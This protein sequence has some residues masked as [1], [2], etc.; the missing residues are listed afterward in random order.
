[1]V[2]PVGLRFYSWSA[3]TPGGLSVNGTLTELKG[4]CVGQWMGW[5]ENAV[6]DTRWAKIIGM[7]KDMGINS[8]RTAHYPRADAFYHAC[9]SVGMMLLVEV[10]NWGTWGGFAGLTT[11]WTRMY[12]CDSE[13][14]LDAYNHPCIW[15]WSLF[16]EPT[17]TNLA[18][19]FANENTI[20]H[21]IEAIAPAGR[22]TLIANFG[23][24]LIYPLDIFGANYQLSVNTTLPMINT[25]NYHNFDRDFTR[26]SAMDLDVSTNSEAYAE[27][28]ST[29][30]GDGM[31]NAWST[32]DKCG[33]AHFWCFMDYCSYLQLHGREGLVDRLYL[34]KNVYF[35]FRNKL[36]GT[37]TD[38]WTNGTATQVA[39]TAD[40]TTLRAD[41]TDISQIVATL[42]NAGGACLHQ[43]CN[44]TFTVTAGA[45]SVAMLY[46]GHSTAPTTGASS[47]T[48][49]VEGGRAGILLRTST[50]P[51]TITVTVTNSCGLTNPPPVTLTSTASAEII[52]AL[53]WDGTSVRSGSQL[54][55]GDVLRLKTVYTGKGI[56][57][58][59][60]SGAEKTVRIINCQG[61][62]VASPTL[63]NGIPAL[64]GHR[65]TGSGIF[66]A[67]WD[68]NGR[69][70]L[71]RLNN[72]R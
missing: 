37:A 71:T 44:I 70:M 22:V 26:G 51:G 3:A 60:P 1:V 41:G 2:E 63:K 50:T 65:V 27:L 33:G 13:M 25:E 52:P 30:S 20:V 49:A 35:M 40:L 62:I 69:R 47:V 72:V 15:G 9:D 14:V 18:T 58:S 54:Q 46:T 59:F 38:Y 19:F 31:I 66:Y 39:L 61:K 34:P 56:M 11:F 55:S 57:I 48:C 23:G 7:I 4:V 10:P 64:V 17:E 6:P 42:R 29:A 5:I 68:D 28:Y 67:V 16:N 32:T 12:C 43:A 21:N 53:V 36:K 45:S 8:I 24:T